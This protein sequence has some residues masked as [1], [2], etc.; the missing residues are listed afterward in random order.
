MNAPKALRDKILA[1]EV[2][3]MM[4]DKTKDSPIIDDTLAA[5]EQGGIPYALIIPAEG[6]GPAIQMPTVMLPGHILEGID[7]AT[8]D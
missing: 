7:I 4:A 1:N 2:V 8:S 5:Y 6:K 3:M